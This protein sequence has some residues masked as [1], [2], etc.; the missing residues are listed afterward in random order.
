MSDYTRGYQDGIV[1]FA[2]AIK[3]FY[4]HLGGKTVGGSVAYHVDQKKREFLGKVETCVA[5]GDVIPEG[6]QV[7]PMCERKDND[8]IKFC[9]RLFDGLFLGHHHNG[10]DDNGKVGE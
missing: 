8:C 2:E 10:R 1:D 4:G 7:C 5:C 3:N 6:R 9:L